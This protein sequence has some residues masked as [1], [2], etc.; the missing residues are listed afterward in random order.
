MVLLLIL[1]SISS[2]PSNFHLPKRAKHVGKREIIRDVQALLLLTSQNMWRTP[3]GARPSHVFRDHNLLDGGVQSRGNILLLRALFVVLLGVLAGQGLGLALSAVVLDQQLSTTI[4]TVFMLTF[5]LSG[6]FFVQHVPWFI[7][8]IK[9][10]SLIQFS[11]KLLL[12]TQ[13]KSGQMYPCDMNK[14]CLVQD[15]PPIK[16][17]GLVER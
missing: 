14:S 11:Y 8:W 6:G 5:Q 15:F 13:Y 16:N 10:L 7:P 1:W 17:V 2:I 9:N 12:S 4:A 3:H